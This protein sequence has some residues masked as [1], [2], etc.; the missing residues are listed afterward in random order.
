MRAAEFTNYETGELTLNHW[1]RGSCKFGVLPANGLLY[2]P[3]DPCT[4]YLQGKLL[5]FYALAPE[6]EREAGSV[7]RLP[8]EALAKEG[9]AEERLEKGPAY[10]KTPQSAI[11]NPQSQ[12][13]PAYRNNSQ[14]T[15]AVATKINPKLKKLWEVGITGRLTQPVIA[16]G[17]VYV[18]SVDEHTL[19]VLDEKTGAKLWTYTAGGRIDTPPTIYGGQRTE[20]RGQR[21]EDRGQRTEDRGQKVGTG[22]LCLFG[23]RNG[24]VYCLRASDGELVWRF[25]AAPR[26]RHVMAEGQVESAWPLHGSVIVA[27]GVV[28]CVAGRSAF[29]DGGVHLYA[30]DAATGKVLEQSVINETQELDSGTAKTMPKETIGATS[31]ILVS[32]GDNI[33][34]QQRK[35]NFSHGLP[36]GLEKRSRARLVVKSSFLD[37]FYFHRTAWSSHRAFGN[38]ISI[39]DNFTVAAAQLPAG[40]MLSG[41]QV[42]V[43]GGGDIS[44]N[45]GHTDTKHMK[46]DKFEEEQAKVKKYVVYGGYNIKAAKNTRMVWELDKFPVCP[47]GLVLTDNAVCI[48]GFFDEVDPKDP[49]ANVEGRK[50]GKLTILSRE[51]GA[52]LSEYDLDSPPVWDGMSAANG[53]LFMSLKNGKVVCFE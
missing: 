13:W 47:Y 33:Y 28:Y 2:K 51:D 15:G 46:E 22:S 5:G 7:K 41:Q 32:D 16:G 53:K 49:W 43:P 4:C 24:W 48:A 52:M 34:M 6:A 14:R 37:G 36:L 3:Q 39:D 10:G 17:K 20:D 31:D 45:L 35:M 11:R 18:C 42:Y 27:K 25:R 19:Y 40:G 23:S 38:L 12:D 44:G 9:E 1:A 21:T 26:E 30:L 8:A 50:G 29:L